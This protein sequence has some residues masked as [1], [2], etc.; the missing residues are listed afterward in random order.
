MTLIDNTATALGNI[1][2]LLR[3]NNLQSITFDIPGA[4]GVA[5]WMR[6][7]VEKM[8]DRGSWTNFLEVRLVQEGQSEAIPS[9][10]VL[11]WC[12]MVEETHWNS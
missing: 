2:E 11:Q 10:S 5:T 9:G 7:L 6:G 12:N 4:C 8:E 1:P 3:N